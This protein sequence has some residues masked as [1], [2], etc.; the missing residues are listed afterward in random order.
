M[1]PNG[2]CFVCGTKNTYTNSTKANA[3]ATACKCISS[4]L[5]W[6]KNGFCDCGNN[7]AMA[8]K[9]N[10]FICVECNSKIR[11]KSKLNSFA[12]ICLNSTILI[13][14]NITAQCDCGL[15][16][17]YLG[18]KCVPCGRALNANG[19]NTSAPTSCK[20]LISAMSWNSKVN[21]CIC[22]SSQVIFTSANGSISCVS[23]GL[24]LN[25]SVTK[26]NQ[27]ACS[28]Y[29]L[30]KWVP[31]KG[32][33]C[34]NPNAFINIISNVPKCIICNADTYSTGRAANGT[35]C[36]C[37]GSLI[38]DTKTLSCGCSSSSARANNGT[39]YCAACKLNIFASTPVISSTNCTCVSK[40]LV[41]YK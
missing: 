17:V 38:W 36:I 18:T 9:G 26:F 32:C 16:S 25:S 8:L 22:N 35:G 1:L 5:T 14:N 28:C 40:A 31:N 33:F 34:S 21:S 19:L 13:W 4:L 11:A 7:S 41:W 27:T 10:S 3:T 23:C 30:F 24:K 20:C 39:Y 2:T 12:C 6:N 15:T 29:T 37:F